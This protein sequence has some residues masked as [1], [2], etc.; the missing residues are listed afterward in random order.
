LAKPIF[1]L[2]EEPLRSRVLARLEKT[3]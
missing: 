3:S 2:M 1:V